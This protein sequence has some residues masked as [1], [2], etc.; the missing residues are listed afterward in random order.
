MERNHL[1][2]WIWRVAGSGSVR[3]AKMMFA[4]QT[5]QVFKL[6]SPE[7]GPPRRKTRTGTISIRIWS[8]LA[9]FLLLVSMRISMLLDLLRMMRYR[10]KPE[11]ES[12][13][14]IL[15]ISLV[16]WWNLVIFGWEIILTTCT[17]WICYCMDVMMHEFGSTI[18]T[19]NSPSWSLKRL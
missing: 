12:W 9:P 14:W 19:E 18:G 5:H 1:D 4:V 10:W 7:S 15:S 17:E 8:I 3:G 2:R 11:V 13:T 16:S 6:L